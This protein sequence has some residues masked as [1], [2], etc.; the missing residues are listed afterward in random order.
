MPQVCKTTELHNF[1][2]GGENV[3]KATVK[4][5]VERRQPTLTTIAVSMAAERFGVEEERGAT[6]LNKTSG[7]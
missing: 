6:L 7:N 4:K 3:L 1:D 2:E 5:N